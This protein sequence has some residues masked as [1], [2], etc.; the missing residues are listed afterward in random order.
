[1][2]NCEHEWQPRPNG[3]KEVCIKCGVAR[4][5]NPENEGYKGDR[6]SLDVHDVKAKL[7]K[8]YHHG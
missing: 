5:I 7:K 4:M 6:F 3:I 1:M 2:S 8:E